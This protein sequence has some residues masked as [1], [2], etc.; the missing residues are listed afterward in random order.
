MHNQQKD[1]VSWNDRVPNVPIYYDAYTVSTLSQYLNSPHTT[2]LEAI[3]W[4]F[5]YL[6]G[7]K[8]LC[9][10]LSG[11]CLSSGSNTNGILGFSN[12]DW[13]S[14]LHWHSISGFT[15]YVGIGA[16]S[17]SAKKQPIVTLLSTESE[18]ITLTHTT[19]D[20]IWIHKLLA[21]LSFFY[22]HKLL[23]PLHCN[24]QGAIKLSKNSWFHARTKHI[25]VHFHFIWQVV[26]KDHIHVNYVPTN[27]MVAD[28]FMKLLR[29]I[30]FELFQELLNIVWAC[31]HWGGVFGHSMLR[32]PLLLLCTILPLLCT[33]C[34]FISL[35]KY[36]TVCLLSVALL[37]CI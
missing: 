26:N 14:H 13:A 7:T 20:I 6:T 1:Y 25:D 35:T 5:C 28:I 30:K 10:I 19:K 27:K 29:C 24:N 11:H 18:Y 33:I 32:D 3:K 34:R 17:W 21:E 15:F 12:A 4:V 36:H 23:T 22:N 9:L 31:S 8:H 2:H 37:T 16:V